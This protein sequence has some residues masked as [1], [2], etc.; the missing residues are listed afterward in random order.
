MHCDELYQKI[1]IIVWF[2]SLLGTALSIHSH[3]VLSTLISYCVDKKVEV[4]STMPKS[5]QEECRVAESGKPILLIS[6]C[7][8][9]NT[10]CYSI[11]A[12][13]LWALLRSRARPHFQGGKEK[14]RAASPLGPC[15]SG[16]LVNTVTCPGGGWDRNGG[17]TLHSRPWV[18]T[19]NSS[20][21]SR[22]AFWQ[23]GM[24]ESY[25]QRRWNPE[26][27]IFQGLWGDSS[28]VGLRTTALMVTML[29]HFTKTEGWTGV[30]ESNGG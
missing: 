19:L 13:K 24:L 2:F 11:I 4:K 30:S 29:M 21:L 20:C 1:E 9:T 17:G 5:Q 16:D 15:V 6:E 22:E 12:P 18:L 23:R 3:L 25:L 26:I 10:F 14:V 7:F 27:M 28:A 8:P